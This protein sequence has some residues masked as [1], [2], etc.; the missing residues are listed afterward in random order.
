M[1]ALTPCFEETSSPLVTRLRK[2]WLALRGPASLRDELERTAVRQFFLCLEHF[3]SAC[4]FDHGEPLLRL[5]EKT[6]L[7]LESSA[8]AR[9][10]IL[11]M[12]KSK[13]LEFDLVYLYGLHH[14]SI[15]SHTQLFAWDDHHALL[16]SRFEKDAEGR[17]LFKVLSR[18]EQERENQELHRLLYV[19]CTGLRNVCFERRR[20]RLPE[21]SSMLKTLCPFL[22]PYDPIPPKAKNTP[23]ETS[24]PKFL[25]RFRSPG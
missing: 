23:S 6:P 20:K 12:H 21:R 3:P 19:A 8:H 18:L 4:D 15:S 14:R 16:A 25:R 1:A 11:T 2:A 24:V 7:S 10:E 13:G 22:P 5:L 9:I 17:S